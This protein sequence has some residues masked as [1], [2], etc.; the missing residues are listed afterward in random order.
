[1]K[2]S[3]ILLVF[4]LCAFLGFSQ[5][6]VPDAIK[7]KFAELYP[8]VNVMEWEAQD[9]F[10]EATFEEKDLETSVLFSSDGRV[11]QTETEISA[12]LLPQTITDYVT[13]NLGGKKIVEASKTVRADGRT[14]FEVEV[15]DT[16][17]LF[18]EKGNY[19]SQKSE[20]EDDE[21][22]DDEDED[23]DDEDEDEDEDEDD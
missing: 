4:S 3:L 20:D 15:D 14:T 21:D 2:H 8:M 19:V 11:V 17:L 23:E 1:M 9:G 10:Y 5:V 12:E 6:I 22:E 7:T 13:I 18:D 16:E